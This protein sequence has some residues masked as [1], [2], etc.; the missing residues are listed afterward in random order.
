VFYAVLE[1]SV[2]LGKLSNDSVGTKRSVPRWKALAEAHHVPGDEAMPGRFMFVQLF[3]RVDFSWGY[4][5]RRGRC[6]LASQ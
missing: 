6:I 1:L 4:S 5:D 3:H 2:P